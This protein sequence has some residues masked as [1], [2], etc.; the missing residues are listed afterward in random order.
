VKSV[1]GNADPRFAKLQSEAKPA[2]GI[3][4]VE[5]FFASSD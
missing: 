2:I 4:G 3:E 1:R 5:V